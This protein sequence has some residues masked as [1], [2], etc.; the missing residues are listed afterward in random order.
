MSD[1]EKEPDVEA[2]P[3]THTQAPPTKLTKAEAEMI[4][5]IESGKKIKEDIFNDK[6]QPIGLYDELTPEDYASAVEEARKNLL[7]RDDFNVDKNLERDL[8]TVPDQNFC[9]VTWVGPTFRAKTDVCGFR[10]MGAFKTLDNA[11]K[12]AQRIHRADPTYD[13][14]IMEM[15]L[16]C[17]GYPDISDSEMTAQQLDQIL[18]Q[19]VIAHKTQL[20]ESKQLFEVRKRAVRKSKI[21][22]EGLEED[23]PLKEVPAG[24][25]T[26]EMQT[27]HDKEAEKWTGAKKSQAPEED[28]YD[29]DSKALDFESGQKIPNQEYAVVSFIGYS[30]TNKRIPI[31]IKGVY[32]TE[33]E[34]EARIKK[35]MHIDDTYDMVPLPLYKWVPCD[36][37]LSLIRNEFKNVNLNNLLEADEKQKEETL[38]FHQVRK[39]YAKPE[40]ALPSLVDLSSP[41]KL[42]Y[43]SEEQKV[44]PEGEEVS[45][46]TA[47]EDVEKQD[48]EDIRI[49]G[50]LI[51]EGLEKIANLG[52]PV[53]EVEFLETFTMNLNLTDKDIKEPMF[54]KADDQL[55]ELEEKIKVLMEIEGISEDEAKDRFRLKFDKMDVKVHEEP[56][57]DLEPIPKPK[58]KSLDFESMA[59]MITDLKAKGHTS[60]EIRKIISERSGDN[61]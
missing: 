55:K 6:V 7:E 36:P 2:P 52:G 38:S 13:T 60:A 43:P 48:S 14:G 16:W 32:A 30:G 18:N 28:D 23:A 45:A 59:E 20:E 5:R 9:V 3:P 26:T 29:I 27:I 35:L 39:K 42:T 56:M 34:A 24:V 54:K 10:I 15:N 12:Y 44:V 46:T 47:L 21:S 51:H 17:F 58:L 40:E 4:D 1:S 31:C 57:P 33:A 8:L 61:A 49:Q 37:D 11:K 19:F 53:S 50:K 41:A 25:P 22:R